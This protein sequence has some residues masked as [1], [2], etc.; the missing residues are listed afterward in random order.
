[1]IRGGDV[2]SGVNRNLLS[3]RLNLRA[4]MPAGRFWRSESNHFEKPSEP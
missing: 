1:V 3:T 4:L 2:A